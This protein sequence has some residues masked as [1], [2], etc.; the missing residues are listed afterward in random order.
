MK[1]RRALFSSSISRIA[2]G[3][4]TLLL[5]GC[6]SSEAEAPADIPAPTEIWTEVDLEL[7]PGPLDFTEMQTGLDTRSGY[8]ATLTITYNG[9]EDG[10]ASQWSSTYVMLRSTWPEAW[11]W[12]ADHGG[13]V[14]SEWQAARS[15]MVY[16]LHEDGA[17][18]GLVPDEANPYVRPEPVDELAGV[19]GAEAGSHDSI[20]GIEADGY[21]FDERALGEE[22]VAESTGELW[23]ASDGG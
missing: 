14:A 10:A 8:K 19:L 21:T 17:C 20:N 7:G 4:L 11:Q 9:T 6:G 18:F 23:L 12:T 5:V 22:G 3:A 1:L 2:L 16:G 13:R 15:G